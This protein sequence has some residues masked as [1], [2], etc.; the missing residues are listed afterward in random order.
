[1]GRW[2]TFALAVAIVLSSC[3]VAAVA[4]LLLTLQ[5][6]VKPDSELH[7]HKV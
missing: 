2:S 4:N 5:S 6:A 3:T 7:E 1:M